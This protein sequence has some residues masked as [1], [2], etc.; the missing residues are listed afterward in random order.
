M[1]WRLR[2]MCP[3]AAPMYDLLAV[4]GRF[5]PFHNDHLDLVRYALT[6]ARR[7]V[8]GI[9]NPD[10]NQC[11]SHPTSPH[12][13]L[14]GSNPFS[15]RQRELLISA[16][17][18]GDAVEP[19]RVLI[20]PFPLDEPGRWPQILPVGTPQLVRTFSDWEREKVRRFAAAGYPPIVL[21]GDPQRRISASEI[22][23]CIAEGGDWQH[24]VPA[25]VRTL[26]SAWLEREGTE[27]HTPH[28]ITGR[29]DADA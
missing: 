2:D 21:Q 11:V 10:A 29:V 17:L 1:P 27:A 24:R 28:L 26:L 7:V 4:T 3:T 8:I 23:D 15:Y 6:Q 12:R 14:A 22:R 20:V 5:Q 19:A 18:A 9:T 25:E 13:H 16:A